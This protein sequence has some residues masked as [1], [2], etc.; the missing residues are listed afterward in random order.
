M[1]NYE[2]AKMAFSW[3]GDIETATSRHSGKEAV[4]IPHK[5]SQFKDAN[6]HIWPQ[7]CWMQDADEV[8]Y[9]LTEWKDFKSTS[10]KLILIAHGAD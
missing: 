5:F 3:D 2:A 8:S 6:L 10:N 1:Q 7:N 9:L 4:E